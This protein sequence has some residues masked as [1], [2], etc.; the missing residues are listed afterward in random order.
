MPGLPNHAHFKV[1]EKVR[2]EFGKCLV[3]TVTEVRGRQVP[4]ARILYRA[5]VPMER[6]VL[7]VEV[8]Q[9]EVEKAHWRQQWLWRSSVA[10]AEFSRSSETPLPHVAARYAILAGPKWAQ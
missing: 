7:M 3:G 10:L 9:N 2:F 6:E 1:G 8:R 4:I 5:R